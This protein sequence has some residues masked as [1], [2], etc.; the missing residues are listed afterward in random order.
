MIQK[1]IIFTKQIWDKETKELTSSNNAHYTK[2]KFKINT[3]GVL[4]RKD[5]KVYFTQDENQ[6]KSDSELLRITKK[7]ET[8]SVD[9]G[10]L[11]KDINSLIA[12]IKEN[13]LLPIIIIVA[14][15]II[16]L[17]IIIMVVKTIIT[18]T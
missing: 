15:S 13:N 9:C 16:C 12:Y 7:N 4:Y 1:K 11:S 14:G 8:Y 10:A 5:N 6:E 2:T 3:S 18:M 17:I